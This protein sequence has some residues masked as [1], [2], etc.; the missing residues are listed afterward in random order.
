MSFATNLCELMQKTGISSY[1]LAKDIG[2]HTS[3][4]TNWR[5][6]K[7]PKVEHLQ[8]VASYFGT[9]ADDLLAEDATVTA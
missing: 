6:G 5:G 4:V 7:S 1:K 2:V 3:T 8:T 9:T